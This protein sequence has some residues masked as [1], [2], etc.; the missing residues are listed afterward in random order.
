ENS[1]GNNYPKVQF[2]ELNTQLEEYRCYSL[3]ESSGLAFDRDVFL[4]N[5]IVGHSNQSGWYFYDRSVVRGPIPFWTISLTENLLLVPGEHGTF[6]ITDRKIPAA[7]DASDCQRY[8]VLL[9][10]SQRKFAKF[11]DNHGVL[12]FDE[13]TDS[14]MQYRATADSDVAFDN[15]RVRG[16]AET[17]GR[18]GHRMGAVES[19]FTI[20]ADGNNYVAKLYSKGLHSFYRLSFDDQ[21]RTICFKRAAQVKLPSAFDRTFYPLCTP[22]EVVFISSDYL[23]VVS[24]SPPSLRHL[25]SW[26]AQQRLA[27]KNTIGAWSGGVS[28]E[29]LKQMCGFRGNRLV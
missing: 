24:H 1:S 5:V 21:Q 12:V 20:F 7:D 27:K 14:W 2:F 19:P 4:D 26:S 10:G 15:A 13:A 18:R 28:E 6:E 23:T 17:F 9:N 25:S 3:H 8:A 16:V 11:T 29:Q 22:S